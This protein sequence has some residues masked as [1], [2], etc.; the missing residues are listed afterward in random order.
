MPSLQFHH[1]S[2]LGGTSELA[3]RIEKFY[4][5]NLGMR[6]AMPSAGT[7]EA[8]FS[9]LADSN[10]PAGLPFEV[11]GVMIEDREEKF[12]ARHGPG[13]DHIC[14]A[15]ESLEE[16]EKVHRSLRAAG[17]KFE[18]EPYDYLGSTITW[19]KD[20]AGVDIELLARTGERPPATK[21]SPPAGPGAHFN[22]VGILT[23]SRE[24]AGATEDFYRKHFGMKVQL[25]GDPT[26]PELDW[27]YLVDGTQ[28]PSLWLEVTGPSL[29]DH[30]HEFLEKHGPG[31][32]HVCFEVKNASEY[33]A[34]L[35]RR[36]VPI[37]F[38][39]EEYMGITMFYVQDPAGVSIQVKEV[40]PAP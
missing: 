29:F 36:G 3:R 20:P 27:V 23:G 31:L 9:F 37:R 12:M 32:D 10:D 8:D 16:F 22:H 28:R 4:M 34:W 24:L 38:E 6:L 13:L 17:I 11:I 2:L 26:N 19:C 30:E 21:V 39:P 7:P 40:A 35:K 15:M 25:R 14:F 33:K 5:D 1:M 18:V